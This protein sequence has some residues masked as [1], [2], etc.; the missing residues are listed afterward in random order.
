M[1]PPSYALVTGASRGIGE[2]FARALAARNRHLVLIARSRKQLESL[3][4]ELRAAHSILAEPLVYDLASDGAVRRLIEELRGRNLQIDLLINNAGFGARGE[5][6]KLPLDDQMRMIRLNVLA[7]AEL[8]HHLLPP[9]VE[10]RSGGIINV[11]SMTGF[12]PIPY[13]A[14]YAATK[15]FVTSFSMGLAEEVRAYGVTVVTLCPGGTRT[16]FVIVGS[17]HGRVR[18]PGNGQPPEEVAEL[19]IESLN[20]AGGLVVPRFINKF[21]VFVQRLLPRRLVPKLVGRMSRP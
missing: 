14:V 13:N 3:A 18:F 8:T 11:S 6:W 2:S 12:Q 5:Y 1:T 4:K 7:L 17:Q 20:R 21:F 10:R 9:M 15:A 16:S 19:A